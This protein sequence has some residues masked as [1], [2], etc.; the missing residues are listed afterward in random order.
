MRKNMDSESNNVVPF[1]KKT[2]P[3][4]SPK[5][6][7]KTYFDPMADYFTSF[8]DDSYYNWSCVPKGKTPREAEIISFPGPKSS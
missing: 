4:F 6:N 1:K 3:M 7:G 5:S 8:L 2:E